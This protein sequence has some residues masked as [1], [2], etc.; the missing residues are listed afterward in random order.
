MHSEPLLEVK[1]LSINFD[2]AE[3][4]AKPLSAVS[5]LSFSLALG[6]TLGIVGESG[7]GK[8]VTC[9]S[10]MGLLPMPPARIVQGQA[11]FDGLDLLTASASTM[12]TIR[13]RRISMIFQDPM[14]SLNPN[15]RIGKQ[16][17]EPLLLHTDVSRQ[18]AKA[19]A[20]KL[21]EEVGIDKP[22]ERYEQY[23]YEFSGGMRQ[24]VMIAMALI[25][26]PDLLIADE[27]TSALDVTVQQQ[28]LGLLAELK[29]TK[30]VS[31]IF[32]SH[33]LDVVKQIA[34]NVIVMQKGVAVEQ[35]SVDKVFNQPAHDYS[36]KLMAAIPTGT[37]ASQYKFKS[38]NGK[39]VLQLDK[40][41][42]SYPL[43][44]NAI[45]AVDE[46]SLTLEKGEVLGIVGESGSGKTTL[47]QSVVRLVDV[48]SGTIQFKQ[49][50]LHSDSGESLQQKR[51][52]IQM[53][54]QDPYASL[55]PRMTVFQ[56]I[57]EPIR[58][59][60]LATNNADVADMVINLMQEVE[61]APEWVNKYPHEFS[62]GQRQ[63]IAIARAVAV[64]PELVIA[65]EPVSA[66]DVT[67]QAQILELLLELVR[68]K[69][70]SM[71][72]ISHDLAVV[73]YMADRIAVMQQGKLV[74]IGEVNQ[75]VNSPQHS[76][77]QA[78]LSAASG[79]RQ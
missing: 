31:L 61:L 51:K 11:K 57:A 29:T 55:N 28:I 76:Y 78:L 26:Q 4:N 48:D 33:D 6:E 8:S 68:T 41:T 53:I 50:S 2:A 73:Q 52:Q 39:P 17:I 34:D 60:K 74:E 79:E 15:M 49:Q 13:G 14:T 20:I 7:S 18:Q 47:S 3:V 63:R 43:G 56:I 45:R 5:N 19:R 38:S 12:R 65:D 64:Q 37:K 22:V 23:P 62:G 21:L 1:N 69:A 67:I 9:Y 59:H 66:L 46:V 72:F 71:I 40:V 27:P 30:H 35:G 24:R 75:I 10:L 16:I 70:L 77:T 32:V 58:L 54:F 36:R 25:T 44:N 42:V